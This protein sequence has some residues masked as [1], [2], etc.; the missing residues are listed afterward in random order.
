MW[1]ASAPVAAQE[2]N[3]FAIG[4]GATHRMSPDPDARGDGGFGLKWRIGHAETGW[5]WHYGLNWYSTNL[6]RDIGGRSTPLGELKIRPF[7]GGYGYTHRLTERLTLAGD[8]IGGFAFSAI[9]LTPSAD[10]A[11]HVPA[12]QNVRVLT[13]STPVLKPEV[14]VWYDLSRKFGISVDA[15]Y[16]LA[17]PKLT[18]ASPG[19]N[20]TE[21]IRADAFTISSGFVYRIF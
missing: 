16:I 7:L 4:A 9:E 3:T 21:R 8:V 19:L 5:G 13:G 10:A 15:G 11:L 18:I 2:H 20:E 1:L 6:D 17:R 12:G 14:S